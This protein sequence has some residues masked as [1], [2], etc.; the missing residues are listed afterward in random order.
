MGKLRESSIVQRQ[1]LN[2]KF[3][4]NIDFGSGK[5]TTT[6][7][8][9]DPESFRAAM[10]YLR[11]FLLQDDVNFGRIHNIINRC[12][13]RKEL[14]AWTR[15][16]NKKWNA[17]LAELPKAAVHA[18]LHGENVSV[19]QSIEKFFYGYGGLFHVDIDEPEQVKSVEAIQ[20]GYLQLAF[21]NLFWCLNVLDSVINWWL[22]A[23]TEK[24][25][26]LSTEESRSS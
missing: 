17:K 4:T 26:P 12:C 20:N 11:Q 1:K 23:T 15:D 10:P 3:S 18:K 13:D 8:G 19:E 5:V 25:P 2:L 24:V 22:D 7:Q 21:P 9:Y 6:V 14:V 16:A